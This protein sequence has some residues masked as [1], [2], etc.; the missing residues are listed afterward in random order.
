M[1]RGLHWWLALVVGVSGYALG[2]GVLKPPSYTAA[3]ATRG[4]ATYVAACAQCHGM[5]LDDGQFAVPLKGPAFRNHWGGG[6]L[7]GPFNVMTTK[8]PPSNPG[9]LPVETYADLL[10]FILSKNGVP[11]G[12]SELPADATELEQMAAPR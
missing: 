4:E 1:S 6:G 2:A 11:S 8:M 3:Q 12:D 9:E 7:D 5:N 10:A